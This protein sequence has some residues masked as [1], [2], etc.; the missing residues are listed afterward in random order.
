M[1]MGL[2]LSIGFVLSF[3]PFLV[4]RQWEDKR[5]RS[6]L[7]HLADAMTVDMV[8]DVRSGLGVIR[9]IGSIYATSEYADRIWM[10]ETAERMLFGQHAVRA[11]SWAPK[12]SDESRRDYEAA[13]RRR[14]EHQD[15]VISERDLQGQLVTAGRRALYFPVVE[16]LPVGLGFGEVSTGL[17]LAS[18]AVLNKALETAW[19]TGD[20]AATPPI[21]ITSG[22]AH[23]RRVVVFFP[24]YRPATTVVDRMKSPQKLIGMLMGIIR[25]K[26]IVEESI[27]EWNGEGI[28]IAAYDKEIGKQYPLV[29]PKDVQS[30]A[31]EESR[32]AWGAPRPDGLRSVTTIE[33]ADRRWVLEFIGTTQFLVTAKAWAGWE[34]LAAGLIFTVL[35]TGYI[36]N[37]RRQGVEVERLVSIRT[38]ELNLANQELAVEITERERVAEALRESEARFRTMAD[39]APVMIWMTEPDGRATFYNKTLLAFTGRSLEEELTNWIA[40]VHPDDRMELKKYWQA[41]AMRQPFAIE[42]RQRRADGAQRWTLDRGTPRF[43]SDGS[44]AGYIGCGIDV[45]DLKEA[46]QVLRQAHDIAIESSR[47]KSEFLANM[48]H[49]IR[50]PMNGIL[51]MT[52]LALQ[53]QLNT[54]QRGYLTLVK[55]SGETLLEIIN[56]ILDFSKIEASRLELEQT[57]FLLRELVGIAIK[58]L[59]LRAHSKKIELSC[60]VAPDVPEA[61]MGDPVR[62]R[63]IVMNLIGN[64]LKF[65]EQGE[66]CLRIELE[67]GDP[68]VVIPTTNNGASVCHLHCMV[69][70]TGIGIPAEKQQLI[71]QPFLQADGSTT[72]HYGG[73]G[74]GLTICLRLVELMGGR[75]WVES[76]Q[77]RG[78]TFHFTIRFGLQEQAEAS[79]LRGSLTLEVLAGLSVL[80]VDDN[81]TSRTILEEWLTAWLMHP[82]ISATGREALE[83]ARQAQKADRPFDLCIIDAEMPEADGF[84]LAAEIMGQSD[85][86][87]PIILMLNAIDQSTDIVRCRDL[88]IDDYVVKPIA[89]SELWDT[90]MT[91]LGKGG[92]GTETA[93]GLQRGAN[94]GDSS[95]STVGGR[96]Y[97]ILLAEDNPVNQ[98]LVVRLLEKEG[99]SVLV[100]GNGRLALAALEQGSFDMILMDIQMPQ[101]D[102][103][104]ATAAIRKREQETDRHIPIVALTAHAMKGDREQCLA[105]GMDEY[106]TKPLR[107]EALFSV[108][109]NLLTGS[110]D[111]AT[112]EADTAP[113]E[114]ISPPL[115][116]TPQPVPAIL[117]P[118][119]DKAE[120][121][122]RVGGDVGLMREITGIFLKEGP[123]HMAEIRTAIDRG[124][125]SAL[126]KAAHTLKG[127]ASVFGARVSVETALR[128]EQ[129]GRTED[130]E[131]AQAGYELLQRAMREL[132]AALEALMNQQ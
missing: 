55:S 35:L 75:I 7:E 39:T 43:L 127:A 88:G 38:D 48:S 65:T 110:P 109:A 85:K 13:I 81:A 99:H 8:H 115:T 84:F 22:Q 61:L 78:S 10:R 53:T 1:L 107:A 70:D 128:L 129:L 11:V 9:S 76:E 44:F 15:F 20:V 101:M 59:A 72:R 100:A 112:V 114:S 125:A 41:F 103:L 116:S 86:R 62:L 2:F 14:I 63:Q 4:V 80:V 57:P 36:S 91:V 130:L 71:F 66:V 118:P 92:S 5:I 102:G 93:E 113:V 120:L 51:G 124:D 34:I 105:A 37:R 90:M 79:T 82:T 49:E 46:E 18:D 106:L 3:I 28:Q 6:D 52:D 77:G 31:Q 95:T 29:T 60:H 132:I 131:H 89:P 64:A 123:T 97:R 54:E 27:E 117:E 26:D 45:T 30:L 19:K 96:T 67:Q 74:L 56:D 111:A 16:T 126:T 104:E 108:I 73:T 23:E 119:F 122:A 121:L 42:Y 17:D 24:V 47:L 25:V 21:S 32:L 58:P 98:M 87:T 12:V 69:T 83:I 68:G 50:T 94:G 40:G 33:V